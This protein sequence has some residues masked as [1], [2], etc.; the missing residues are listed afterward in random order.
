VFSVFIIIV[1]S[2]RFVDFDNELL[3]HSGLTVMKS[4]T[5][6]LRKNIV[7]LIITSLLSACRTGQFVPVTTAI[8]V[9]IE[10]SFPTEVISESKSGDD[11]TPSLTRE[12]TRA[13]PTT[14]QSIEQ[15][16]A[17]NPDC[18]KAEFISDVTI[19]DGSMMTR[20]EVFLKIWR[21]KNTGDCVWPE[22]L[23][24]E[25]AGGDVLGNTQAASFKPHPHGVPLQDSMG[26]RAWADL[27]LAEVQP[28]ETI[29][30]PL[31]FQA[32]DAG[33]DYYSVWSLQSPALGA[34]LLQVYVQIRVEDIETPEPTIWGGEWRQ[35][36]LQTGS[37][38]SS[39][40][41][42]E[43]NFQVRGYFYTPSGELYLL[44]GGLFDLGIRVEG[45]FGPPYH[46]GFPFTWQ[47]AD[48]GQSFQGFFQD[49]L[50]S[51]GAWCG[52]RSESNLPDP[53]VLKP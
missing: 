44:E 13:T 41:L 21:L 40:F 20:D 15:D 48:D 28:G 34:A 42:E 31:M 36:N 3:F 23:V 5:Y 22:D 8:D 49:Q 45:T 52:A 11:A 33:G 43:D 35:L 37:G 12:S 14:T 6:G 32:P 1:A 46:D 4:L 51:A 53:C 30:F 17:L 47:L 7:A 2:I 18:Y 38:L 16:S 19:P 10:Q 27:I 29:D 24:L 26:E 50:I 39:L 9:E 25:F